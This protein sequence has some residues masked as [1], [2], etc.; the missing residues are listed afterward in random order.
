M[1]SFEW[2]LMEI[3]VRLCEEPG[4]LL[5]LGSQIRFTASIQSLHQKMVCCTQQERMEHWGCKCLFSIFALLMGF[6]IYQIF[7]YRMVLFYFWLGEDIRDRASIFS[8]QQGWRCHWAERPL[9]KMEDYLVC[10]SFYHVFVGIMKW[11]MM[12]FSLLGT[13]TQ[14]SC[15]HCNRYDPE[16][17]T[18]KK[19]YDPELQHIKSSN[20]NYL[21][22]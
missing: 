9:A 12:G 8:Y 17:V 6:V 13:V 16:I 5:L 19:R 14:C 15:L 22:F 20:E 10:F 2:G 11:L 7:K 21:N 4:F 18:K 1:P 3:T